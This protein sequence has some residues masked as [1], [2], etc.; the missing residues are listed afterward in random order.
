MKITSDRAFLKMKTKFN[1]GRYCEALNG[2]NSKLSVR[3]KEMEVYLLK[4]FYKAPCVEKT[5][6]EIITF[7]GV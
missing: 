6:G 5:T 4:S 1:G 7:N 2:L 3:F